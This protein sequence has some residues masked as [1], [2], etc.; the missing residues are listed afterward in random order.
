MTTS[1]TPKHRAGSTTDC[2]CWSLRRSADG[3]SRP[4]G[5][6]GEN[7]SRADQ[8]WA[9]SWSSWSISSLSCGCLE[10]VDYIG[11]SIVCN[12]WLRCLCG[13]LAVVCRCIHE[14]GVAI[15]RHGMPAQQIATASRR[16][17]E[18]PVPL[19]S[20]GRFAEHRRGVEAPRPQRCRALISRRRKAK[21]PARGR[22][23][24]GS[25]TD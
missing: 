13:I 7:H 5:A 17:L 9:S 21:E 10:H 1:R 22:L 23:L 25:R 16:W 11:P 12:G 4:A 19:H 14:T 24:P 3:G 8:P 18:T 6:A 2:G 15:W 20:T